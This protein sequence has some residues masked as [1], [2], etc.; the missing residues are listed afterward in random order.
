M[1][2]FVLTKNAWTESLFRFLNNEK[3]TPSEVFFK[4]FNLKFIP[5]PLIYTVFRI[6]V[7]VTDIFDI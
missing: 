2:A 7:F 6:V 5:A 3:N 4:D 1:P